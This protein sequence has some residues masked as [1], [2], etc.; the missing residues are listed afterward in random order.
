M[1]AD[2][3][4]AAIGPW[5]LAFAKPKPTEITPGTKNPDKTKA[6]PAEGRAT[7]QGIFP[8]KNPRDSLNIRYRERWA[9]AK[10]GF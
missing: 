2:R 4:R 5:L 1:C 10:G 7:P 3:K 6:S 9:M 8:L